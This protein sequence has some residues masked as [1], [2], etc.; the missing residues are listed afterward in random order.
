MLPVNKKTTTEAVNNVPMNNIYHIMS[1]LDNGH[2]GLTFTEF[3]VKYNITYIMFATDFLYTVYI[4]F[5]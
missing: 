1:H 3:C 5:Q 4:R 2:N